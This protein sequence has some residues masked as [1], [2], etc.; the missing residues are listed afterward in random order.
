MIGRHD[1]RYIVAIGVVDSSGFRRGARHP[2]SDE[3]DDDRCWE[4][5]EK[6]PDSAWHGE[7]ESDECGHEER[8]PAGAPRSDLAAPLSPLRSQRQ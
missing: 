2:E 8:R 6:L 7:E 5:M 1:A 4:S 3:K